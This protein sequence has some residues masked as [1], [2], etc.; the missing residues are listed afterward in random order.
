MLDQDL[1]E[2]IRN[3]DAEEARRIIS[4]KKIDV[5]EIELGGLG[6]T[7]LYWAAKYGA[8]NAAQVL[9]EAGAD[10]NVKELKDGD[11]PINLAAINGHAN[12]VKRLLDAG[13]DPTIEN[14]DGEVAFDMAS[15]FKRTEA[16]QIL[17]DAMNER[18]SRSRVNR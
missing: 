1:F 9:I 16:A 3:D 4:S 7:Y 5:N 11:T 14:R 8:D 10:V 6:D 18:K 2:A 17:Q 12:V 15:R 13:A